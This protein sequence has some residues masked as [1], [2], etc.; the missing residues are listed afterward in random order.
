MIV[1]LWVCL[2]VVSNS[3]FSLAPEGQLATFNQIFQT[4]ACH[5]KFQSEDLMISLPTSL[6]FSIETLSYEGYGPEWL[7]YSIIL[8]Y[9]LECYTSSVRL[10]VE[11]NLEVCL[12]CDSKKFYDDLLER[13]HSHGFMFNEAD[14]VSFVDA[15]L[16]QLQS[17]K[18]L[19]GLK[20]PISWY[21]YSGRPSTVSVTFSST[22]QMTNIAL[23]ISDQDFFI[24]QFEKMSHLKFFDVQKEQLFYFLRQ[25]ATCLSQSSHLRYEKVYT[26][27][28]ALSFFDE[29]KNTD[30]L[31]IFCGVLDEVLSADY[32]YSAVYDRFVQEFKFTA[33]QIAFYLYRA[34]LSDFRINDSLPTFLKNVL[35]VLSES[36]QVIVDV[37]PELDPLCGGLGRVEK[38]HLSAMAHLGAR[39]IVLQPFYTHDKHGKKTNILER[40]RH[41]ASLVISSDLDFLGENESYKIQVYQ[42]TDSTL[43]YDLIYLQF[44]SD[45]LQLYGQDS[46]SDKLSFSYKF[47]LA[48]KAFLKEKE[49]FLDEDEE[50]AV[51]N[52][53]D[54]QSAFVPA[55]LESERYYQSNFLSKTQIVMTTH[56]YNN[57]LFVYDHQTVERHIPRSFYHFGYGYHPG[58]N[59][60]TWDMTTLGI[61]FASKSK[62]V[63]NLHAIEKQPHTPLRSLVGIP[64]G[65]DLQQTTSV[66][67]QFLPSEY[68]N[69]TYFQLASLSDDILKPLIMEAKCEAREAFAQWVCQNYES[70]Y[71]QTF[72]PSLPILSYSGRMVREKACSRALTEKNIE[73]LLARGVNVVIFGSV[74]DMGGDSSYLFQR[75]K[76]ILG[77]V[78]TQN[79]SGRLILAS[80]FSREEQYLLL[81]A[82]T[83]QVQDSDRATGAAE[84]TESNAGSN[85]GIQLSPPY[86]EG[87]I[88]SH[89]VPVCFPV[90]NEEEGKTSEMNFK[91]RKGC[92]LVP[93]SIQSD[94]YLSV[95]ESFF[96]L[97]PQDQLDYQIYAFRNNRV[98]DAQMTAL[99]YLYF[100]GEDMNFR[101]SHV[102]LMNS[103]PLDCLRPEIDCYE[104]YVEPQDRR[105]SLSSNKSYQECFFQKE[106]KHRGGEFEAVSKRLSKTYR[107]VVVKEGR[108]KWV[109]GKYDKR[110]SFRESSNNSSTSLE[111]EVQEEEKKW[112]GE[113][114]KEK[115]QVHQGSK[116][117]FHVSCRVKLN[118][119]PYSSFG[120]VIR[121]GVQTYYAHME[122]RYPDSEDPN[123]TRYVF[124][125]SLPPSFLLPLKGQ[126]Q[127][128]ILQ[129]AY[130][131]SFIDDP[132]PLDIEPRIDLGSRSQ[133]KKPQS[134]LKTD[135]VNI[136]G[137]DFTEESLNQAFQPSDSLMKSLSSLNE[138]LFIDKLDQIQSE[139]KLL[140]EHSYPVLE[141]PS[142]SE[143]SFT[144]LPVM[145]LI[146]NPLNFTLLRASFNE[147]LSDQNPSPLSEQ[148]RNLQIQE[149]LD[150]LEKYR[151][152]GW[153]KDVFGEDNQNVQVY[154]HEE[155]AVYL[156]SCPSDATEAE[157]QTYRVFASNTVVFPSR[158][159]GGRAQIHIRYDSRLLHFAQRKN[160]NQDQLNLL[161]DFILINE[162]VQG[163]YRLK[164]GLETLSKEQRNSIELGSQLVALLCLAHLN[165]EGEAVSNRLTDIQKSLT[166]FLRTR[167][168][169]FFQ[170]DKSNL[171]ASA[172]EQEAF[173]IEERQFNL[174]FDLARKCSSFDSYHD[175]SAFE[176][177]LNEHEDSSLKQDWAQCVQLS[178]LMTFSA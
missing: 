55:I 178:Q 25:I 125:V 92:V 31:S 14:L 47:A 134:L 35:P 75:F 54:A 118:H 104:I 97:K 44:D 166:P 17:Q 33:L 77:K 6:P 147:E 101:R 58:T 159:T 50:I 80:Q 122:A 27:L 70:E 158:E 105:F 23:W 138:K 161:Y 99:N 106:K 126:T 9:L 2:S 160:M 103:V 146:E 149:G 90:N 173:S 176:A 10:S 120:L 162:L 3:L 128:I 29:G 91:K 83:V 67:R 148:A 144:S 48:V 119:W 82:T 22:L 98:L 8:S 168:T 142:S 11:R 157:K 4:D 133:K 85:G 174:L 136:L 141:T 13:F 109:S 114:I 59:K 132:I 87:L 43:P 16:R 123:Y 64:N 175:L 140:R 39:V 66:L 167:G 79:Y 60:I 110:Y 76:D 152:C 112:E 121:S 37:T 12:T 88:A 57:R 5:P 34:G 73:A 84:Y 130:L 32:T 177:Q 41:C 46:T 107:S 49:L 36:N 86:H 102:D 94:A 131:S 45:S 63:S 72:N 93:S 71:A 163:H 170:P 69:K 145:N 38:D 7:H 52:C 113:V 116:V 117:C 153:F 56:T 28:R 169:Y 40:S 156:S 1:F 100:F 65:S 143:G 108:K 62:G 78:S 127:K 171:D 129:F 124:L 42:S 111:G 95:L 61:N 96:N 26:V 15:K 89:G 21:D 135:T 172:V 24:A 53:N 81:A 74:Q 137:S 51:V 115:L 155:E 30:F 19:S 68:R 150:R 165:C 151:S 139:K 18:I 20:L 164:Q 154:F